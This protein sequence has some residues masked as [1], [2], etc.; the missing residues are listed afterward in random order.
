MERLFGTDGVRGVANR[1]LTPEMALRLG[2]AGA[3]VLTRAKETARAPRILVGKDTRISGDMLEAALTAGMCS[4]GAEVYHAG[5]IPT[6]GIAHLVR[7]YKLD[8]GVMISASHNPMQ[9]NGIKFFNAD[10]FKLPDAQEDEI[11]AIYRSRGTADGTELPC[12]EGADVGAKRDCP[13]ATDD[14]VD[15]L[16]STV[17]GLSLDGLRIALDC[18]NGAT[19]LIAPQV[20]ARLG[21]TPFTLH[22]RPDGV[23][24][25][26]GCGSTHIESLRAYVAEHHMDIGFAFDGDGDRMLAVD[27]TGE[28]VDGDQILAVCAK[29]LHSRGLLKHG[30]LVATVM[31]NLGLSLMC[32]RH[33]ITLCQ[34]DVG[35]RYVLEKMLA[36]DYILGGE[37]S[38]HIIFK[39]HNTTGDGLLTALQLLSV[40]RREGK[41]LSALK[42]VM[43]ILPQAL[44]NVRVSNGR[45][46]ALLENEPIARL[47][48]QT[49]STLHGEGRVLVRPSGTEPL[50][51]VMIEGA[52]RAHIDR[53]AGD[54]AQLIERELG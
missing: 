15:F 31:S 46:Q 52:D 14:Y 40:I 20:F 45:K 17:P 18:A 44:V 4:L 36:E 50:V 35:D 8:A 42:T 30:A 23:N 33:G 32:R 12:P 25:N 27:D 43:D 10:G 1:E 53:L 24:I 38:G 21:A 34:T 11:E 49:E 2:R 54:L 5:V 51:R 29:D 16:I 47:I 37:Q 41:P 39:T 48:A 6:P 22:H 19:S 9:D 7:A 3:Y 28:I 26:D 13:R